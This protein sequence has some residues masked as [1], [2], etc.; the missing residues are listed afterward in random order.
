MP[1][2]VIGIAAVTDFAAVSVVIGLSPERDTTQ[3]EVRELR[4]GAK[5]LVERT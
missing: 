2:I 3:P 4:A 5:R 1:M